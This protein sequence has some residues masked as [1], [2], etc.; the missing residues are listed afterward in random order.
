MIRIGVVTVFWVG[1]VMTSTVR[2]KSCV[3]AAGMVISRLTTSPL[4]TWA[5]VTSP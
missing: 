4:K 1:L 2:A 3:P 5:G